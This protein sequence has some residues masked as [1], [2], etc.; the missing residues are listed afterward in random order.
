[1]NTQLINDLK[2]IKHN[3][4][5]A[6]VIRQR[7]LESIPMIKDQ[8]KDNRLLVVEIIGENIVCLIENMPS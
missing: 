4:L 2:E 1:M 8:I 6:D 7:P 3:S 5:F